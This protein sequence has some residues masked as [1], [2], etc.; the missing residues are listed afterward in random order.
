MLRPAL[1]GGVHSPVS[2]RVFIKRLAAVE[3]DPWRSN[4]HEFN[5]GRLRRELGFSHNSTRGRVDFLFYKAD[6]AEPVVVRERYTLYDARRNVPRRTEWRMYYSNLGVAAHSRV[7]DLMLLSR[8]DPKSTDLVAVIARQGTAVERALARQLVG[9]EPQDIGDKLFVDSGNV[10]PG[11]RKLLLRALKGSKPHGVLR[12]DAARAHPLFKHSVA[13][14]TMPNTRKMAAAAQEIV[15]DHGVTATEPDDFIAMALEAETNL[16]MSIEKTFGKRKLDQ[17]VKE[18]TMDFHAVMK[19]C[20]S[21]SQRRKSRRGHSLENHFRS[22]LDEMKIPYGYQCI[23][24]SGRKPDFLF[25]SCDDYHNPNYPTKL[26]R[27]VGCKT[28]VRERHTQWL[29]E[30][31]RIP[32][33]YALCVDPELSDRMIRR[34]GR[35]LRFFLPQKLLDGTY[36]DREIRDLLGSVADLIDNLRS[37]GKPSFG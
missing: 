5:A 21:F 36:A 8:P 16:F 15:A 3:I 17:V 34:Y 33:K 14:G 9:C 24:E 28:L 7:N 35:R 26:L 2:V 11:T 13:Y 31:S 4:Q 30:A 20:M 37:V 32:M 12:P 19:I 23:T 18:G 6:E 10:D 27:M 1:A 29:T 22:L 25:P